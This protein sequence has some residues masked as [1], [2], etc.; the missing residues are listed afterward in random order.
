[1]KSLYDGKSVYEIAIKTV[2]ESNGHVLCTIKRCCFIT[3]GVDKFPLIKKLF[4]VD[5]V[6]RFD[7]ILS[8]S[9]VGPIYFVDHNFFRGFSL[10]LGNSDSSCP[11]PRQFS[12]AS[13]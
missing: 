12:V 11:F 8:I 13:R 6:V 7:K 3:T 2:I 1:M 10:S 5:L 9:G 4:A